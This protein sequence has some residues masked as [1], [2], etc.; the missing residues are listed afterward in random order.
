MAAELA[1]EL[2]VLAA[3]LGLERVVVEGRGDLAP[4]LAVAVA[5]R[6]LETGHVLTRDDTV[7]RVLPVDAVPD[8]AIGDGDEL[9]GRTVTPAIVA[10]EVLS[11]QRLAPDGLEGIAALVP[12]GRRAIAIPIEGTGLAVRV[13]DRVDVLDPTVDGRG[14]GDSGG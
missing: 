4:G 3:W 11:A 2:A 8:A 13:D 12:A 1:E 6:R 10:G 14:S 5:R 9:A 7:V